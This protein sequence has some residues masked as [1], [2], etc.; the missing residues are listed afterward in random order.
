MV[1]VLAWTPVTEMLPLALPPAM[2]S[3]AG[4]MVAVA[5]ALLAREMVTPPVGAGLARVTV[6]GTTFPW[7]MLVKGSDRVIARGL[8]LRSVVPSSYPVAKAVSVA[9]PLL[10]AVVTVK[11]AVVFPMRTQTLVAGLAEGVEM[12]PIEG[13]LKAS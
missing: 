9:E 3:E 12:T 6:P 5:L 1:A 4:A 8:T 13:T 10:A 11:V 2:K 7:P